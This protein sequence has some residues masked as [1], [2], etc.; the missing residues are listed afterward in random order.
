MKG[1][2]TSLQSLKLNEKHVGDVCHNLRYQFDFDTSEN[3]KEI[4]KKV[5]SNIH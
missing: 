4:F 3:S 2:G 5:A 1:P